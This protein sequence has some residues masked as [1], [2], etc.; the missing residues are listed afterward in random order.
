MNKPLLSLLIFFLTIPCFSQLLEGFENTPGIS[1]PLPATW[2]L[3]SGNWAVFEQN[4]NANSG[5]MQS[6]GINAFAIGLQYE[7][8]QCA[9]VSRENIGAGN[10]SQDFLV[11]PVV[12]IPTTGGEL[13]FFTRTFVSGN[14][15]TRFKIMIAPAAN[16]SVQFDATAYATIQEWNDGELIVPSS[17]FNVWTEKIVTLP[18]FIAGQDVYVAFVREYT[19]LTDS[20]DGDRWLIDNV[21]LNGDLGC[22][23]SA[24]AAASSATSVDLTVFTN[25]PNPIEAMILPCDDPA[26]LPTDN[27]VAVIGNTYEFTNLTPNTCYEVYVKNSCSATPYWQQVNIVYSLGRISLVAF[28]D[29]NNNG[30]KD[31]DEPYF[32]NGQFT[33]TDNASGYVLN[34]YTSYY[35]FIPNPT[36]TTLNF[37]YQIPSPF[38]IC[39]TLGTSNYNNIE[40]S[41]DTQTLYFPV[42]PTAGCF[43]T[44]V[45]LGSNRSPRP[46]MT[47]PDYVTVYTFGDN[48]PSTGTLTY[49]KSPQ[50]NID[51]V[52]PSAG[53]TLT[54]TGFTY[55]YSG[56]TYQIPINLTIMTSVPP[57][58]TVNIGDVLGSSASV[59][60]TPADTNPSNDSANLTQTVVG[61]YDPNDIKESRGPRIQFDQFGANDY[62]YYTIRFQNT[63]N[64]N[65]IKVRVDHALD[66]KIDETSIS[67]IAASHDYLVVRTGNNLVWE[68]NNI[69]LPP[70]SVNENLS[71]GFITFRVKLKPGFA[72]GD[73]IPAQASI[74]FDSNPAIV[75]ENFITEFVQQLGN[76][77]F[78]PNAVSLHPNPAD[79]VVSLTNESLEKIAKA[80]IYDIS[81]K[82]IYELND[83]PNTIS[84]DVS[85]FARGMYLIELF[86]ENNYKITKKLVL[87]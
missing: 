50:V 85:H 64:A 77:T 20:I 25:N 61:S 7:G 81:G 57:I 2:T 44:Q 86:S 72:I 54:P 48:P 59:F 75:T 49:T 18:S 87:K 42:V 69:Q 33:V 12:S 73:I 29:S 32:K 83:V 30:I 47:D 45:V 4:S 70:A 43:D 15:N 53:V 55:T 84:I 16:P 56:L 23:V 5:T 13:R 71:N 24:A 74:Y 37:S 34:V 6:W 22:Y 31:N 36:S 35:S 76:S 65:A 66:T 62:L 58:P 27:G 8:I 68:F 39:A 3:G 11:T 79:D 17:N 60:F 63:G 9:S 21:N 82:K 14:Q 28:V 80:S 41:F 10:T 51:S 52:F 67:M 1:G 40:P 46:G 26:P 19:Q 78:E 38:N